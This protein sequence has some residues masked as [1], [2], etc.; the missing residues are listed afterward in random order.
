MLIDYH[1][2][3]ENGPYTM[4]WLQRFVDQA[5]AA[6]I[7]EI[8]FTEHGHR[9]VA[10]Q[11]IVD[12]DIVRG[13]GGQDV[14]AY[15]RLVADAKKEGWPVKLGLEMDYVPGKEKEIASF[16][17]SYPWDYVI[18][19]V[20]WDGDFALDLPVHKPEWGRRGVDNVYRR[21]F[22]LVRQA[23]KTG[24]FDVM[25]HADL[26]KIYGYRPSSAFDLEQEY[27]VTAQAFA[28]AG[29]AVEVSTA[30]LRRPVGEIYPAARF[31]AACH[32]CGVPITLASDAHH[33]EDVGFAI[34][35]AV[36]WVRNCGYGDLVTFTGRRPHRA[37][38]G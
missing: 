15:V 6:G 12:N 21:Y 14:E 24:L 7:A 9:F 33:P 32:E 16:L 17:G 27:R 35:S 8:G 4:E 31:L 11:G 2:H 13:W 25:G 29:V 34:Q 28:V 38:L 22:E 19:S 18:G 37:P 1:T 36:A 23:A 3:L 10:A 20:H 26:V 5:R 30:G